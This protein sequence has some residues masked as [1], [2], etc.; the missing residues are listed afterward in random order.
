MGIS[1][2]GSQCTC[3]GFLPL[4]SAGENQSGHVIFYY[5][6]QQRWGSHTRHTSPCLSCH[7]V[8]VRECWA[9]KYSH[10]SNW[11]SWAGRIHP[12]FGLFSTVSAQK[13]IVLRSLS[14]LQGQHFYKLS[15][16]TAGIT[17]LH[18]KQFL[19]FFS[20][21]WWGQ[22][23]KTYISR[24]NVGYCSNKL[25]EPPESAALFKKKKMQTSK[26]KLSKQIHNFLLSVKS[27]SF[28]VFIQ[29]KPDVFP[30]QKWFGIALTVVQLCSVL[31]IWEDA[32][33]LQMFIS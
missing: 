6:L 31:A 28:S 11:P 21:K 13:C 25:P 1:G 15:L 14:G 12:L 30:Q 2:S 3:M 20:L 27:I 16:K 9:H 23:H 8:L 22:F 17:T 10:N 4:L 7:S 18:R 5:Q 29:L 26:H 24:W 33:L 32:F 19:I